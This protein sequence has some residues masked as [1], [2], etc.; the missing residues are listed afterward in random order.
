M[1]QTISVFKKGVLRVEAIRGKAPSAP[2]SAGPQEQQLIKTFHRD[3]CWEEEELSS[4]PL[5]P[6]DLS[7]KG[8]GR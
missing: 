3:G 8:E 1:S 2:G 5:A 6:R 4:P 7:L